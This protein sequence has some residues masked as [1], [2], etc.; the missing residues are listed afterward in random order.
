MTPYN[1]G[2]VQIGLL[3]TKPM[4]VPDEHMERVQAALCPPC[5]RI[6]ATHRLTLG[7]AAREALMI[8]GF[9]TFF[10]LIGYS[11]D[12]WNFFA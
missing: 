12:L 11:P 2:K 8:A 9:A 6:I 3:H 1:T 4:S 10:I 5:K 7:A